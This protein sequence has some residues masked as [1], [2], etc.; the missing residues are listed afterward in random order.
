MKIYPLDEDGMRKLDKI[1]T[2]L[3]GNGSHLTPDARRDLAHQLN[4]LCNELRQCETVWCPACSGTGKLPD[5]KTCTS[6]DADYE[7][8]F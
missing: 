6:C 4:T 1:A 5:G 3:Y 8:A 2:A 7:Q